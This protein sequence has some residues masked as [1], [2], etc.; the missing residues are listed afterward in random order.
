MI[1][2]PSDTH[3]LIRH[4]VLRCCRLAL[5]MAFWRLRRRSSLGGTY[6]RFLRTVL[7]IRDRVTSLRNRLSKL[8]GDSPGRS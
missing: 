2:Q 4:S 6:H 1:V 3:S 7:R 5:R 8:S